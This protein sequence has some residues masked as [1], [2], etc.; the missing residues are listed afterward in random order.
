MTDYL[1]T[2]SERFNKYYHNYRI[3][4][5]EAAVREARLLL[6]KSVQLVIQSGL[7]LLGMK[8]PEEM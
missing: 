2:L 3:L 5:D 8:A 4:T 7:R 1:L 6:V